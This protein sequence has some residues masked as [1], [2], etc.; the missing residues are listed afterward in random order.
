M[1]YY[2]TY[3][4]KYMTSQTLRALINEEFKRGKK[5]QSIQ[6][7]V[8]KLLDLFESEQ[9]LNNY[10]PGTIHN[11]FDFFDKCFCNPKNGGS[12]VCGCI[13]SQRHTF[14]NS[15]ATSTQNSQ[16]QLLNG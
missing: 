7:S 12:G 3:S 15:V 4:N 5:L 11:S 6:E 1:L 14:T 16:Q 8:N 2:K 10:S 13:L 9:L